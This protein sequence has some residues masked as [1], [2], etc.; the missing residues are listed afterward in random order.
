[1]N[2]A[3]RRQAE[4][5]LREAPALLLV[6]VAQPPENLLGPLAGRIQIG[7]RQELGL[8]A[9]IP[10][11]LGGGV[12]ANQR[13]GGRLDGAGEQEIML[14]H[15]LRHR[16]VAALLLGHAH[17]AGQETVGDADA[18]AAT[19]GRDERGSIGRQHVVGQREDLLCQNLAAD[20]VESQPRAIPLGVGHVGLTLAR[21]EH[22]LHQRDRA[23][24]CQRQDTALVGFGHRTGLLLS[25]GCDNLTG[26]VFESAVIGIALSGLYL[27]KTMPMICFTKHNHYL[28]RTN[29]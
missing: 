27:P 1:M 2:L 19:G 22:L 23:T 10:G 7:H 24:N 20:L 16:P 4:V 18:R 21:A 17:L 11:E 3:H 6:A 8:G 9:G 13:G 25:V 14:V 5:G 28:Q 15:L 29:L 26:K 12:E